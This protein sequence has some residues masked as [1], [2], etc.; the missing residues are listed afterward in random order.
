MHIAD[1][2]DRSAVEA[3]LQATTK[4]A[5]LREL[6]SLAARAHPELDPHALFDTLMAREK[7]QSTGVGEGYAIPHGKTSAVPGIVACVGRSPAGLDFQSLDHKPTHIFFVLLV[8]ES[9]A[10]LHLKAL[11]RVSR[12]IREPRVR[13]SLLTVDSAD[14]MFELIVTEDARL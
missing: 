6:V 8:P 9:S 12:L 1:F 13:E 3:N 10:A 14:A 7:L 5:V 11:A 4:P 2:L